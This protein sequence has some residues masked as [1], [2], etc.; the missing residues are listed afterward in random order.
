MKEGEDFPYCGFPEPWY[1]DEGQKHP[2]WEIFY[3]EGLY[4]KPEVKHAAVNPPPKKETIEEPELEDP[5]GVLAEI[6][7]IGEA[8]DEFDPTFFIETVEMEEVIIEG[9][10]DTEK[11]VKNVKS[12]WDCLFKS[13]P[14]YQ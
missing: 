9:R 1:D 3:E 13:V 7:A 5:L 11:V 6:L 4:V 8:E 2:G 14:C 12:M 10:V